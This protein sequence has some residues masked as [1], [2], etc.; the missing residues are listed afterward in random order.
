MKN[1]CA[2]LAAQYEATGPF[3]IDAIDAHSQ[4]GDRDL[5]RQRF[6]KAVR[7][8]YF[9]VEECPDGKRKHSLY[10]PTELLDAYMNN[11]PVHAMPDR[12][13]LCDFFGGMRV[14]PSFY[15]P[16]PGAHIHKTPWE[17]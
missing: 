7:A 11:C 14:P 6:Y 5:N 9:V 17:E 2:A 16:Y 15:Q 4:Y 3:G 1:F 8:G 12:P 10:K 13:D